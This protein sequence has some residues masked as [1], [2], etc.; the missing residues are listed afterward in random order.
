MKPKLTKEQSQALAIMNT[1]ANIFLTGNAGTGKSFVLQSFIDQHK[2]DNVIVTAPTGVAALNVGG[3]TLHRTLSLTPDDNLT[4]KIAKSN[5]TLAEADILVVDEISMCRSDLF[6]YLIKTI[7]ATEK[8]EKNHIQLVVVGDFCQL[9]PVVA[10]E[11]EKA[12]FA[13]GKEFAFNSDYWAKCK[14]TTITLK[15]V[16]RQKNRQFTD[17]LNKI[18]IGD[19]SGLDFIK[20]SSAKKKIKNAITLCGRNR[21]ADDINEESL[22]LI[23]ERPYRFE[24][25]IEGTVK[26][27]DKPLPDTIYLK[28]TARV[29]IMINDKK[30]KY[31]NGT[32]GVITD[33]AEQNDDPV[34]TVKL[35]DGDEV[36]LTPAT[37]SIY[38]YELV[39]KGKKLSLEKVKVGSFTQIPLKPAYAVTIH[40]SQGQTYDAVNFDPEIWA[41]GQLY[42]ALS[43]VTDV[44]KLHCTSRITKAMV[45]LDP[46][47]KQFYKK[48]NDH[49]GGRRKNAGRKRSVEGMKSKAIRLP[50]VLT[51]PLA[52]AKKLP[53]DDILELRKQIID[54]VQKHKAD[55]K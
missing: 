21:T 17:A 11:E 12:Y 4:T 35:E 41:S 48:L 15:N 39:K 47:I 22:D 38:K 9:P 28:K 8:K 31:S 7:H 16:V 42:V 14:F 23:D 50:E 46:T 54:F 26:N 24:S 29:V 32:I 2:N 37:W 10:T 18:R 52:E 6:N 27:S 49:R 53:A 55:K 19:A 1:G 13:G 40:K 20:K 51:D 43:R 30:G 34:V 33:I 5:D 45:K 3:A 25:A 36:A 44:K